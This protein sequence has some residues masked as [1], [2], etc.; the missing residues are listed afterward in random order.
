MTDQN[1]AGTEA[2]IPRWVRRL[3]SLSHFHTPLPK[4]A[5]SAAANSDATF[6]RLAELFGA[7]PDP[8]AVRFQIT[9][10]E[11][12]SVWV[13]DAGPAGCQVTD[14]ATRPVAA[15]AIL[16]AGTWTLIA[17][18]RLSFLE[19]FARGR[20]RVRGDLRTAR[21]VA[22]QLYQQDSPNS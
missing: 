11:Q 13:L 16:E 14:D 15:E 19:A 9:D 2:G 1:E 18:G 4:L 5:E 6:V 3:P 20:M 22:R 8:L 21:R 12:T 10:G 7:T 17:D